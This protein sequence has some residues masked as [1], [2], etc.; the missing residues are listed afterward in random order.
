MVSHHTKVLIGQRVAYVRLSGREAPFPT[1]YG[2]MYCIFTVTYLEVLEMH[3]ALT[4]R[5]AL[6]S[7]L[8]DCE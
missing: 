2:R 4:P 5:H 1:L 8:V 6:H 7:D 3:D